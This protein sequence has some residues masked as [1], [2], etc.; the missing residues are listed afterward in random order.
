NLPEA[1]VERIQE[2]LGAIAALFAEGKLKPL[3]LRTFPLDS[4]SDALRFI[5]Q[6]RHVGKVVL[7]PTQRRGMVDPDGA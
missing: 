7:V 4:A 3:P 2:M 5:A 6:A 1:G